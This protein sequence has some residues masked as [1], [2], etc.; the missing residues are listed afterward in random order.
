MPVFITIR[1]FDAFMKANL[2]RNKSKL[3]TRRRNVNTKESQ[4]AL[5]N[6]AKFLV[7]LKKA[8]LKNTKKSYQ[9][10]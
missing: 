6:L 3:I 9:E 10:L 8:H 4:A 1:K 7:D 2:L 5:P